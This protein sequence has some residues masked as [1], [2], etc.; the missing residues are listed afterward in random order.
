MSKLSDSMA[1]LSQRAK[2]AEQQ[3]T[4][5]VK[6]TR[7]EIEKRIAQVK[8]DG[9]ALRE[10]FRTRR[11]EAKTES[12]ARWSALRTG[13]QEH[14]DQMRQQAD[15]RR[16]DRDAKVAERRAERAETNAADAIDFAAYAIEEAQVTALEATEARAIADSL[17]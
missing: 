13:V 10:D 12:A 11:A 9:L 14:F 5:A 7:D 16:N 1:E 8:N 2:T 17:K 4:A 15:E 6:E 3:T